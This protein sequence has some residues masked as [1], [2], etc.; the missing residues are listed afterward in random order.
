MLDSERKWA[1]GCYIPIFNVVVCVLA[2]IRKVSSHF[3]LFHARQG[4]V[5]FGLWLF[6][7]LV[8]LISQSLS[9]MLW[10]VVLFFHF[11]GIAISFKPEIVKIPVFGNFALK[12]PEFYLFEL[13][14]GRKAEQIVD[15]KT[16]GVT[17]ESKADSTT[18]PPE[19]VDKTGGN[20]GD[21]ANSV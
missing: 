11:Y 4:L 16:T 2:S 3:C 1:I 21:S 7:I 19:S 17:E 20:S 13:L 12:M 18:M 9:L 15:G 5:L 6:T 14:T 10:G 8:A